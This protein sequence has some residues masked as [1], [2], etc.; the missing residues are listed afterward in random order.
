MQRRRDADHG[1]RP[2]FAIHRFQV[3]ALCL[4]SGKMDC[5]DDV[6]SRKQMFCAPL[7][8]GWHKEVLDCNSPFT[9]GASQRPLSVECDQGR[10]WIRWM[11]CH[12][13]AHIEERVQGIFSF[14]C[15]AGIPAVEPALHM[16]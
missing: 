3:D 6:V 15:V 4:N 10:R 8:Y 7:L 9:S 13:W 11:D 5:L 2:D 1:E 14:T 12:A 16:G